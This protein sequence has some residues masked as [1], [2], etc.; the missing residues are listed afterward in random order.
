MC[1]GD[2]TRLGRWYGTNKASTKQLYTPLYEVHLGKMRRR[3]LKLLEIGIGGYGA[4]LQSGGA[5]LRMWRS[6][7]PRAEIVGIDIEPR[8]FDEPRI[9]TYT[10]DQ[11][12]EV[13][14]RNV[15]RLAGPFDIVIDDGSHRSDDVVGSF[16]VLWALL[17]PG[18]VYVIEDLGT[19]YLSEFGGGPP[20]TPGTTVEMVKDL[21]DSPT[22]D[23]DVA[24][25]HMHPHIVFIE[26]S[27]RATPNPDR[28]R[29]RS[30]GEGRSC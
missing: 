27:S 14:L 21:L 30:S 3:H 28:D 6:W 1:R 25:V 9:S 8:T 26:K 12:D 5:S 17:E 19:S 20:G 2:L 13:F 11:S 22:L 7:M 16:Q 15:C 29:F 23:G 18:G 10:G 4:G 24:A